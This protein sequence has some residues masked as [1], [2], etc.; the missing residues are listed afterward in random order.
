[1]GPHPEFF[2]TLSPHPPAPQPLP[3]PTHLSPSVGIVGAAQT[4]LLAASL[5][6]PTRAVAVLTTASAY[7]S[8]GRGHDG[9]EQDR[10]DNACSKGHD[11]REAHPGAEK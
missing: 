7:T 6:E 2:Y 5:S 9:A 3:V 10:N 1:M 4:G 11:E 8:K